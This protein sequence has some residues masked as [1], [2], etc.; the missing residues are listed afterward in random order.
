MIIAIGCA[1]GRIMSTLGLPFAVLWSIAVLYVTLGFRQFS[2]HFT[3]IRD[4]LDEGDEPLARSLL[5]HWQGVDSAELPRS[6]KRR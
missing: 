5:A 6:E 3:D 2:H 4:A 1:A